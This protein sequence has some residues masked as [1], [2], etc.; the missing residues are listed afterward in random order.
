MVRWFWQRRRP[1]GRVLRLRSRDEASDVRRVDFEQLA[2]DV[3]TYLGQAAYL[4]LGYVETISAL[5][6]RSPEL[7]HKESLS[8]AAG[9]ALLKHQ[10]LLDLIRDRGEDPLRLMLPFREPLDVFRRAT[11]GARA[12]ETMLSV[13][14]TAGLLDDFYLSLSG[15]YG[16]TGRRVAA[17][18]RADADRSALVGII[19]DA[20]A[21]DDEWR[22]ILSMWGRR[23]VGDTLLVARGALRPGGLDRAD[24]K[25]VEPVFTQLLAAHSK[26]MTAIGLDA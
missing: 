14:I 24:E 13:H 26:R 5:I 23:L 21:A 16:D 9:A 11:H 25:Q 8:R 10:G 22:S 7:S 3:A 19:T 6:E 2:P 15:S 18:L 12:L 1:P 17:V 4:Q 20:I